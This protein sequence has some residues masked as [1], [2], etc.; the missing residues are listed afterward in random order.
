MLAEI[1]PF[2]TSPA[3][4]YFEEIGQAK[5]KVEG[6]L[7]LLADLHHAGRITDEDYQND[8]APLAKQLEELER[9]QAQQDQNKG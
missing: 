6:Q 9:K 3:A 2:H 8:I 7:E 1:V 4:A 5:G